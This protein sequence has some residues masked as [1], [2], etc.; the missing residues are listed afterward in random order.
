MTFKIFKKH[1][2]VIK[3]KWSAYA[4]GVLSLYYRVLVSDVTS[5]VIC[6][7]DGV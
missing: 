5:L 3:R 1:I 7:I 2:Y 4:V 6:D